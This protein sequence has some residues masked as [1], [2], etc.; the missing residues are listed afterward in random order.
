MTRAQRRVPRKD[1]RHEPQPAVE[2]GDNP[3]PRSLGVQRRAAA[4]LALAV[5]A[6]LFAAADSF[7]AGVAH[8]NLSNDGFVRT[9]QWTPDDFGLAYEDVTI[10]SDG[11]RLAGWW[12]PAGPGPNAATT[13]ILVHGYSSN[14]SKVMRLWAPNLHDA[15]YS[16]LT[17]DLR[18]HGAS[19]DTNGLVTY[20]VDEAKDVLAAVAYVRA[21]AA[22]LG[23]DPDRIVLYG[24]SMGAA[25]VLNAAGQHPPGVVAVV[26][27]SSFASFSFEAAI[28][29]AAKGYPGLV[30]DW[31]VARMDRLASAPPTDSRPERAL[32]GLQVPVLLAHCTD[33]TNITPPNFKRLQE[34]APAGTVTW[35]AACPTGLSKEHHVDGWAQPG[36]NQTVRSFL[37][38][39]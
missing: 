18:N 17:L 33:D 37:A 20:G 13:T 27:D 6:V 19:P 1:M 15:G 34:R 3:P 11:L 39:V 2:K 30:V 24:G 22:A 29:G 21:N 12:I 25:A 7:L 26:A 14:M 38:G 23:V 16:V 10:E 4:V 36:Y 35:T 31:V 9:H 28:D 5:V 32:A 8:D